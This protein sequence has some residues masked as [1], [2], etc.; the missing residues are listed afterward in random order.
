MMLRKTSSWF[1][2]YTF[3]RRARTLVR[4]AVGFAIFG[5]GVAVIVVYLMRRMSDG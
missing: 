4:K 2:R 5:S 1:V 3:R